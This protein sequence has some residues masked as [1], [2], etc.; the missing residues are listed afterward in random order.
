MRR[1]WKSS[2]SWA[3]TCWAAWTSCRCPA[4]HLQQFAHAW[5]HVHVHARMP[6]S[7]HA[8]PLKCW[9]LLVGWGT[10]ESKG[11]TGCSK[12]WSTMFDGPMPIDLMLFCRRMRRI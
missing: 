11:G 12:H 10:A 5:T 2:C 3:S 7:M 4:L 6:Q 9:S 1:C 8:A